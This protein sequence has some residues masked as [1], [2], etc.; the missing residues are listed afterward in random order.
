MKY[1]KSTMVVRNFKQRKEFYI[2]EKYYSAKEAAEEFD[3]SE[4]TLKDWLRA[5]K[6]K[7]EK[8]GRA[9]RIADSVL[10][11]Y[12]KLPDPNE[13]LIDEVDLRYLLMDIQKQLFAVDEAKGY[14]MRRSKALRWAGMLEKI[15][16][17]AEYEHP[18]S[19][20]GRKSKAN[21]P[22]LSN[23]LSHKNKSI[24]TF[25]ENMI[26]CLTVYPD[27]LDNKDVIKAVGL[28]KDKIKKI[29][30]DRI[31]RKPIIS[32]IVNQLEKLEYYCLQYISKY[33]K[34]N[35]VYYS[36]SYILASEFLLFEECLPPQIKKMSIE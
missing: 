16:E 31:E 26:Y 34:E 27:I 1:N 10:R 13:D 35:D 6:L 15:I 24:V 19:I 32:K 11:E 3:L 21:R 36:D 18:G 14:R 17:E 23:Y 4:K 12:L 33:E 8:S 29:D 5:G 22:E 25:I 20:V 7:G 28:I 30:E 2:M 9:W